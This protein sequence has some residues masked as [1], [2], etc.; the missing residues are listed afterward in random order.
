MKELVVHIGHG[1]T[2]TTAIQNQLYAARHV[3]RE[4]GIIYPEV[5]IP[6]VVGP[7][8]QTA[9]HWLCNNLNSNDKCCLDDLDAVRSRLAR[10]KNDADK[11]DSARVIISSELLCYANE[12]I[13]RVYKE[14]FHDYKITVVYFIRRQDDLIKS[15]YLQVVKQGRDK[16]KP[17]GNSKNL[18]DFVKHGW[19]GFLFLN[20]AE[21]WSS[22]IGDENIRIILYHNKLFSDSFSAFKEAIGLAL[23]FDP[24]IDSRPNNGIL[25]EFVNLID[26]MDGGEINFDTRW[27]IIHELERLSSIFKSQSAGLPDPEGW[28]DALK[29]YYAENNNNLATRFLT[30]Q[31][32]PY[33]TFECDEPLPR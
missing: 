15:A 4:C 30:G 1:K 19:R 27:K 3:L 32:L 33:L 18:L 16:S 8:L 14:V 28:L 29:G 7:I 6:P 21:R 9:H 22:T 24:N 17:W 25:T 11:I 13:P 5:G 31:Y 20:L 12:N 2:G 10:I 23:E 26:V